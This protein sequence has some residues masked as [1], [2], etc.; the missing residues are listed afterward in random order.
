MEEVASG[1]SVVTNSSQKE[2]IILMLLTCDDYDDN[3]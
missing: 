1:A 2:K 3:V